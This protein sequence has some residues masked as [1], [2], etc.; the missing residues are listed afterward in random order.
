[1]S[2]T[3]AHETTPEAC[4]LNVDGCSR[5]SVSDTSLCFNHKSALGWIFGKLFLVCLVLFLCWLVQQIQKSKTSILLNYNN[6]PLNNPVW[7]FTILQLVEGITVISVSHAFWTRSWMLSAFSQ[8]FTQLA[9]IEIHLL[10]KVTICRKL[11]WTED[12]GP[13]Y[14]TIFVDCIEYRMPI[15]QVFFWKKV[16]GRYSTQ[17][18]DCPRR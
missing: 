10:L 5:C 12:L 1:M 14:G 13:N 17:W 15:L 2:S 11:A 16:K 6:A 7:I 3:A 18:F 9:Y 4:R 8:V